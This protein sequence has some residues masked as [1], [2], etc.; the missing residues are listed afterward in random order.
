MVTVGFDFGTHQT[1]VCYETIEVGTTFYEVFRFR[2]TRGEDELTLPSLVRLYADGTLRYGHDA[3]A[4]E[5]GSQ[6]ITYFKQKMFSLA[7]TAKDRDDAKQWAVLYLAFIVFKLDEHF[8]GEPYTVQMGMPT[9]ADHHHYDFCKRQALTVMASA[10]LLVRKVFKGDLNA[11]LRTQHHKL[12]DVVGQCLALIPNDMREVQER[13]PILVF[14]EA[15][16]A[17]I[18]LINDH[19]LPEIGPNLFVDI[20]GGTVDISFFT[21]QMDSSAGLNRPCLY[22]YHSVPYGLN[23]IT[24]QD[25]RQSHN[26]KI[27]QDQI[28]REGVDRF[29][30][31]LKSAVDTMMERLELEY[32]R[33]G[34]TGVMTFQSLCYQMLTGRPICYSGGG[35]MFSGLRLPISR[36]GKINYKFTDVKTVSGLIDHSKLHVSDEMFHVLATAFALS[37]QSLISRGRNEGPDAIVLVSVERLFDGIKLPKLPTGQQFPSEITR[38]GTVDLIKYDYTTD[39][40]RA[41][42]GD[43]AAKRRIE[44]AHATG[45]IPIGIKISGELAAECLRQME[46]RRAEE[47]EQNRHILETRRKFDELVKESRRQIAEA[48]AAFKDGDFRSA[49]RVATLILKAPDFSSSRFEEAR[50]WLNMAKEKGFVSLVLLRLFASVCRQGRIPKAKKHLRRYEMII[51]DCQSGKISGVTFCDV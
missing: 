51:S 1:K 38:Y 25:M 36:A 43:I 34:K 40:Q 8:R 39:L 7:A 22:Y 50:D 5:T 44:E 41:M 29:G 12:V 37:H 17:L 6:A 26:I 11:F 9:D 47:E 23:M 14:P 18:P 10:M 48:K 24:G 42:S 46:K 30:E 21:N 49:I 27:L 19:K 31:K 32:T 35:S 20:G 4:N 16:A 28:T 15:Y 13:F 3:A 45:N 2:S 33:L